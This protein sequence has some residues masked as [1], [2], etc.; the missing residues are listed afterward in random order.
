M[1]FDKF[2]FRSLTLKKFAFTYEFRNEFF[3]I[4]GDVFVAK[5]EFPKTIT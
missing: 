4:S 3:Q 5:L 1:N 2:V